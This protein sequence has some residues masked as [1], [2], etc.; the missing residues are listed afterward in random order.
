M[1]R[2]VLNTR[3]V[4]RLLPRRYADVAVDEGALL[5]AGL[6][7]LFATS[8]EHATVPM[9]PFAIDD[10]TTEEKRDPEHIF[11]LGY[12]AF[13]KA[14]LEARMGAR[15]PELVA[16]VETKPMASFPVGTRLDFRTRICPTIRSKR[17]HPSETARQK[18]YELDVWLAER[19]AEWEL[20]KPALWDSARPFDVHSDRERSYG[21]WLRRE[22]LGVTATGEA[23]P[24]RVPAAELEGSARLV[25]FRQDPFHRTP[26]KHSRDGGKGPKRPNAVL[27]GTLRVTDSA[28]FTSLLA[29]GI[30]RHRAYGFGMLLVR[31]AG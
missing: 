10:R 29:R 12:S 15:R 1:V 14:E 21:D 9:Q 17:A 26:T 2:L 19:F 7:N 30:G 25:E 31:R 5:H 13:D 27:E 22:M 6:A 16:D 18:A 24:Q 28:A 4:V 23:R 20:Q 11:L 8:S 3:P